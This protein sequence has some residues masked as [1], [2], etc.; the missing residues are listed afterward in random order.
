MTRPSNRPNLETL[1]EHGGWVRALARSLVN[2]QATAEDFEQEVWLAAAERP[3]LQIS[4]PRGWLGAVARNIA[5]MHWREQ[6]A[7][8]RREEIVSD[9][10]SK[11]ETNAGSSRN[12]DYLVDRM[13]TFRK[14]SAA[15][16]NL[17]D[18][19]G[20]TLYLRFFESL[21]V[22]EI[23]ERMQVP[24]SAV[25]KR[26]ARGLGMLRGQLEASIGKDWRP[27]CLALATPFTTAQV[28][29]LSTISTISVMTAKTKIIIGAAALALL[30]LPLLKPWQAPEPFAPE[31]VGT[32]ANLEE[33]AAPAESLNSA[34]IHRTV[35]EAIA[36]NGNPLVTLP[37]QVTVLDADGIGIQDTRIFAWHDEELR[38]EVSTNEAG[39]VTLYELNGDGGLVVLA[40]H[41]LPLYLPQHFDGTPINVHPTLGETLSGQVTFLRPRVELDP[42][43][44]RVITSLA[45]KV[46]PMPTVVA[47]LL[48]ELDV[49]PGSAD[50]VVDAQ[51]SFHVSGLPKGWAG[52][53][54]FPYGFLICSF[55]GPG[56]LGW[57]LD[58]VIELPH[59]SMNIKVE[60]LELPVF[61]GRIVSSDS[62]EGVP[63]AGLFVSPYMTEAHSDT[64]LIGG[65][66]DQDGFFRVPMAVGNSTNRKEWPK[67]P[68]LAFLPPFTVEVDVASSDHYAGA[69]EILNV[70]NNINPWDLGVITVG[71]LST[72][73]LLIVDIN[74]QPIEGALAS[75]VRLSS[76][77]NALGMTELLLS[78]DS[79]SAS[80]GAPGFQSVVVPLP[81]SQEELWKAVLR[82]SAQLKVTWDTPVDFDMSSLVFRIESKDDLFLNKGNAWLFT[83]WSFRTAAGLDFAAGGNSRTKGRY[84]EWHLRPSQNEFSVWGLNPGASIRVMLRDRANQELASSSIVLSAEETRAIELHIEHLP[85]PLTGVVL[86]VNGSPINAA[87]LSVAGYHVSTTPEGWFDIGYFAGPTVALGVEKSGFARGRESE[88][89]LPQQGQSV[90]IILEESREVTLYFRDAAGLIYAGGHISGPGKAKQSN[91]EDGPG[92]IFQELPQSSFSVH[93]SIGGANG[94]A[95][96]PA[97]ISEYSIE[98]PS[99]ASAIIRATR[100]NTEE[101]QSIRLTFV[102]TNKS[103]QASEDS[104]YQ[105]SLSL[106]VGVASQTKKFPAL[107]P[108]EYMVEYS[109]WCKTDGQWNYK[110]LGTQ[111]PVLATAGQALELDLSY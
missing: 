5:G 4:N 2:D 75:A 60:L 25:K 43:V 84:M 6:S 94:D 90:E 47:D 45:P 33:P 7:R 12:P 104:L 65:S 108:G 81:D 36:T 77:T 88:Y 109:T 92:H 51:G 31:L 74:D 19:Y 86:D 34:T 49:R 35:A 89:L 50:A 91:P 80:V 111:G 38:E 52:H 66:T 98:V 9:Q 95:W 39:Q 41:F 14:L 28:A 64:T 32:Q 97:N 61:T 3:H 11:D 79:D 54:R 1:L 53:I 42:L 48:K 18:P 101:Q 87:D 96:I 23:A 82:P 62:G 107:L 71:R 69:A 8:R 29:T 57:E 72:R 26:I 70:N 37:V 100:A 68:E 46:E 27:N 76:P 105:R 22:R 78:E 56:E 63:N 15:M 30:T 103:A 58:R 44:I 83:E 85:R 99:M 20:T 55:E 13:E 16:A 17:P 73:P 40:P 93:W 110:P 59:A 106:P 67:N 102:P 21:K 24:E 10:R